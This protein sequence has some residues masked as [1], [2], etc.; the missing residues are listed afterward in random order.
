M[1]RWPG[2]SRRRV[3]TYRSAKEFARGDRTGAL[4]I[5][6]PL[7]ANTSSNIGVNLL[8]RSRIRNMKRPARSPRSISRLRAC[9]AVH[10]PVGCAGTPRICTRRVSISI[11]KKTCRRLRNTVSACTKSHGNIPDAWDVRN[12]R[13]VGDARRGAGLSPAAARIRRIVPSPMRWPRPRSSPWLCRCLHRFANRI[14]ELLANTNTTQGAKTVNF[15]TAL[16]ALA[17][18]PLNGDQVERAANRIVELLDHAEDAEAAQF[19]TALA[20]LAVHPLNGGQ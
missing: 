17:V 6:T 9:W 7:P 16:A 18:H 4:M 11:T 1:S 13:Q 14:V 10:A 19:G 8:S 20:A 2:H 3:P 5:R 12:C 15:G